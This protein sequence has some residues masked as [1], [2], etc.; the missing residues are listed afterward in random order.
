MAS[1]N[2]APYQGGGGTKRGGDLASARALFRT[3]LS[4]LFLISC[5]INLLYLTGS[6]FML[7][8]YD[9][10][11]PAR[12][13]PTLVAIGG[14]VA[15]LYLFHGG[16]EFI[17]QRVFV[18]MGTALDNE[19]SRGVFHSMLAMAV[20]PKIANA[21]QPVQDLDNVRNFLANGGP[22]AFFDLPWL[23]LYLA[24]CFVF[25]PW[26]GFTA[27]GG[28]LILILLTRLTES[29]TQKPLADAT[30]HLLHRDAL[31]DASRRNV[32]SVQAMG[33]TDRLGELWR[34][35]N[36]AF[37]A[38]NSKASDVGLGYGTA[39]KI[40]RMALQSFTLA[41]C[42]YL[43]IRQ[44]ATAG[45]MIASSIIVSRA[46]APIEGAI[47][48]WKNFVKA[49]HSWKRLDQFLSRTVEVERLA[50]PAPHR[51]FT[52]ERL[53]LGAPA[54][55]RVLVS[56]ITFRLRPGDSLG[57]I[58]RSGSGKSSLA[59]GLVGVWQPYRGA[60]RL[61]GAALDQWTPHALGR[62]IGYL[63][64]NVELF[65]GTLAQNI[66]R[67]DPEANAGDIIEA[68]QAAG[69][70]DMVTRLPKGYDTELGTDGGMLSGGQRQR[71]GLARALYQRPFLVVLDEPNSN[72]DSEGED[73]LIRAIQGV[74]ERNGIVVL[75]AHRP[76]TLAA[77]NLVL[78]MHNG[79]MQKFGEREEVTRSL[80]GGS[81]APSAIKVIAKDED[82]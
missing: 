38:A 12:S 48:Q 1:T 36:G 57:I 65:A 29:G 31:A 21:A 63:P 6:F 5:V 52:V 41:I 10:V 77:S 80:V 50:L 69:I 60:V 53:T 42:A 70:H 64:Q 58:G 68:A 30:R 44:E 35:S 26:V 8:V 59:R 20:V 66:A 18:R 43:V 81:P 13:V 3:T 7:E 55:N 17:R 24:I 54:D 76:S 25:H 32:E 28:A 4:G 16:L 49:R 40:T 45:V 74:R 56:D 73:A 61:D 2:L 62:H 9:R 23:P 75:I 78:V 51:E 71:V 22:I 82:A 14:I 19:I 67:F 47:G 27:I 33:M 15:V 34:R 79:T 72:L 37:I 39:S 46:L 11:L